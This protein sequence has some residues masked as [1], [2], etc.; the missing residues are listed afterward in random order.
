MAD[1][2]HPPKELSMT[3]RSIDVTRRRDQDLTCSTQPPIGN[4][5]PAGN[6]AGV[7]LGVS[8]GTAFGLTH[9]TT[10]T[11]TTSPISETGEP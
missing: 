1:G 2:K 8:R 11:A 7:G 3:D 4:D 6:S 9:T 10:V 5:A